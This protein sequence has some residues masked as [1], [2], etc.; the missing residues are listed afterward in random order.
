MNTLSALK[1]PMFPKTHSTTQVSENQ[2]TG[3]VG[4]SLQA[5]DSRNSDRIFVSA[6]T[7][8][9]AV[10]RLLYLDKKSFWLDEII[11]VSIAKLD[12][13][14]FRNIV[15]S[16]EA[17]M[18]LYY[19]LLRLWWHIGQS[20]FAV[21]L[22]SVIPAIATVPL[23]YLLGRRLFSRQVG[24]VAALLLAVNAFHIRYSQEARSYSLYLFLVVLACWFYVEA[25]TQGAEEKSVHRHWIALGLAAT[26]AIYSH[27]FAALMLAVF[28]VAP[29]LSPVRRTF[30]WKPLLLTT[31]AIAVATLP[32]GLFLVLKDKGQMDWVPPFRLRQLYDLFALLS[33]RGGMVLLLLCGAGLLIALW[34][35]AASWRTRVQAVESWNYDFVWTW[36]LLP[37]LLTI[38]ISLVKPMF[39]PRFLLL[40][41][42]P[43]VLLVA[44]GLWSIQPKWLRMTALLVLIGLSV[45]GV[46]SYYQ[47][48]FDPPEQ[49]WRGVVHYVLSDAEPGDAIFFYHPLAR[50]PWEYYSARSVRSDEHPVPA[51]IF[52]LR[53]DARLLKGVPLSIEPLIQAPT[54][55][56]RLW[57]V[58]NYGP[59]TFTKKTQ[60][61]LG[62][63]YSVAKR[64][65]FGIIR[66]IL[67][68]KR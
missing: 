57:L 67:F 43:F 15:M 51:V 21:R 64:R 46:V 50:L 16:W 28:W 53:G 44:A 59:D 6:T 45:R 7:V 35:T 11:S 52:P 8:F 39:V 49:D 37:L 66:V 19:A 17:N 54:Q 47:T 34:D 12:G 30:P 63:N 36:L 58:Q 60:I 18:A 40:C 5:F 56:H 61:A 20:E 42:P 33:G 55:Y 31:V 14:G 68:E 65:E 4:R 22:L 9:A 24:I 23:I 27:F 38:G 3:R 1:A 48:G 29:T 62:K 10:L 25:V 2:A 32:L 41:L 26:L 13:A